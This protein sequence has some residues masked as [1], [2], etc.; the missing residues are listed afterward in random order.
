MT[1]ISSRSTVS[2][3][4]RSPSNPFVLDV[5][6]AIGLDNNF[7]LRFVSA[8]YDL[9]LIFI[10]SLPVAG[11]FAGALWR[12]FFSDGGKCV[13]RQKTGRVNDS[14]LRGGGAGGLTPPGLICELAEITEDVSS[15]TSDSKSGAL[16]V[17]AF[18]FLFCKN[19]VVNVF[20]L[21]PMHDLHTNMVI[22]LLSN[23]SWVVGYVV[24]VRITSQTGGNG[25]RGQQDGLLVWGVV[26]YASKTSG[27]V[28]GLWVVGSGDV[29]ESDNW[30][31]SC[32]GHHS[33]TV[34]LTT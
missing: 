5:V 6:P 14:L 13:L 9:D 11:L 7:F 21:G 22:F 8:S 26:S 19:L 2:V 10:Y 20:T 25:T 3:V 29:R 1:L 23:C 32:C 15:L 30:F 34:I 31:R 24:V 12:G 16:E 33:T 27:D 28:N 18:Y 4:N 17:Q